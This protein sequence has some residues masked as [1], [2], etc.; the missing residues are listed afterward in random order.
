MELSQ[1]YSYFFVST[2]FPNF[3]KL[4]SLMILSF[5]IILLTLELCNFFFFGWIISSVS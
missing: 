1:V 2:F 4:I 5:D 3:M